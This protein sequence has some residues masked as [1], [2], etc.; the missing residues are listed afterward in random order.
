MYARIPAQLMLVLF[1]SGGEV[2]IG[3]RSRKI[4]VAFTV[5]SSTVKLQDAKS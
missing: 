5:N 1:D 3:I 4:F 2:Y